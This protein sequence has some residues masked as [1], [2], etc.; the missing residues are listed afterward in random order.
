MLFRHLYGPQASGCQGDGSLPWFFLFN[1]DQLLGLFLAAERLLFSLG[2][3]PWLRFGG[4][5][6]LI[7][8]NPLSVP[9]SLSPCLF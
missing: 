1:V 4:G 5:S 6:C 3:H 2:S 7:S 9:N 8:I